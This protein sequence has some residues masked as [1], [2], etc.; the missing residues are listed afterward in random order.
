MTKPIAQTFYINETR[1]GVEG[2]VLTRLD[3]YFESVSP[4]FGV[5]IQIRETDNGNPTPSILPRASKVIHL[6]D[7][8]ASNV[9]FLDSKGATKTIAAGTQI[10][11]SSTDATF[12]VVFEFDTP[13]TLQ[14]QTSYAFVI[15]PI[16]GNPDY[17]VWVSELGPKAGDD[18]TTGSP[19]Y[20]NNDTGTLFLSSNDIQFTSVPG[21]DI[22]F[23]AYIANFT[24]QKGTAAYITFPEE[25]IYYTN[26]IGSFQPNETMLLGNNSIDLAAI[27]T[28]ANT[29]AFTIGETVY[30]SNGSANNATGVVYGWKA[31]AGTG[32]LL[33]KNSNGVFVTSNASSLKITGVT[34][35]A[36]ANV[37]SA[38]QSVISS[39]NTTLTVP[40]TGNSTIGYAF[41][42]NQSLYIG[43]SDRATV[44]CK[45]VNAVINSTAVS[46]KYPTSFTDS[47]SILGQLRGDNL[48]LWARYSGPQGNDPVLRFGQSS[49]WASLYLS[50]SNSTVNFAN[51]QGQLLIGFSSKSSALNQ[52]VLDYPY[53]AVIPDFTQLTSKNTNIEWTYYGIDTD[54]TY[55]AAGIP[56]V[57]G[58]D[59]QLLDKPRMLLSRTSEVTKNSGNSS[60]TLFANLTSSNT[61]FSPIID[62]MMNNVRFTRNFVASAKQT[63]GYYI[64]T[65][66]RNGAFNI[67][68]IKGSIVSQSNGSVIVTGQILAQNPTGVYIA[69]TSGAFRS[70]YSIYQTNNTSINCMAVSVTEYDEKYTANVFPYLPR[71]ISKNVLL[72]ENQDA[73]DLKIYLTAYRP[74]NTNF[75]IYGKFLHNQDPENFGNKIW[76]RLTENTVSTA[77]ISSGSNEDDFLELMYELPVSLVLSQNNVTCNTTSANITFGS[78]GSTAGISNGNIIYLYNSSS[79]NFITRQVSYVANNSTL[80]LTAIPSYASTNSDLGIITGAEHP[81]AA[82]LYANNNNIVRYV[83]NNGVVFD[84]YKSFAVK[85]VP[86]SDSTSIVPRAGDYRALALQV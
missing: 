11:Q 16:G 58:V 37:T 48:G 74:A 54:G 50:T 22:K 9:T 45:V 10:I 57:N 47:A 59:K 15:I 12:P 6:T 18:I 63:S 39:S 25:G 36:T 62:G 76:S 19:V 86:V 75:Q 52:D 70:G 82:F 34:S 49:Y 69:N 27:V 5:E 65:S 85:I 78:L 4:T 55:D 30:Q 14:S 67:G 42:A 71:Y 1:G 46:L 64:S 35:S 8:H 21:E 13:I 53:N 29:G 77:L 38:N 56:V 7:T 43:T 32:E 24:S 31:T 2:V 79:N 61:K 66:N 73:E 26:L 40:F 20:T 41:Y 44:D 68:V 33:V 80:V 28:N 51:A 60:L 72:A 83:S 84:T 81:A 3:I 17:R 23:T